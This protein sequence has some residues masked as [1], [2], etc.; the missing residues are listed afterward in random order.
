[1]TTAPNDFGFAAILDGVGGSNL[2]SLRSVDRGAR[3][4]FLR[5]YPVETK[6]IGHERM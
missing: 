6:I 4:A 5:M 1:M 3:R 2:Y